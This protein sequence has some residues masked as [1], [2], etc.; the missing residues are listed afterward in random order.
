MKTIL[1]LNGKK[2]DLNACSREQLIRIIEYLA[3]YAQIPNQK[4]KRKI[5]NIE[6]NFLEEQMRYN[7]EEDEERWYQNLNY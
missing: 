6:E 1:E 4:P 5:G 7:N 2:V 3:K